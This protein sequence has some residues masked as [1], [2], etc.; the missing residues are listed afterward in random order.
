MLMRDRLKV[1]F[2]ENYRVSLAETVMPATELSEQI[3]IAG[4][5]ASGTGNMKFMFNG[6]L[7]VGTLDGANVEMF[8]A[9]GAENIFIFGLQAGEVEALIKNGTYSPGLIYQQNEKLRRILD[10]ISDGFSDGES[11]SDI[12]QSL[13]IGAGREPDPYMVLADYQSYADIQ[14]KV[15]ETYR[16]PERWNDMAIVNIAGAGRFASDRSIEDYARTI[17]HIPVRE[18]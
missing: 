6:A 13:L 12:A 14:A 4:T 15:S 2:L 18:T 16:N 11:Y 3:S 10:M 5:E 1:V 7:T 9:V 17:W 8:E